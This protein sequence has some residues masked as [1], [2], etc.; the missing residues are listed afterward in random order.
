MTDSHNAAPYAADD[1]GNDDPILDDAR[2]RETVT[3][4]AVAGET[5]LP[6]EAD[7]EDGPIGG[8]PGEAQPTYADG[9]L[10]PEDVDLG[11]EEP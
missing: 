8:M 9:D 6:N 5:V 10:S 3:N 11:D 7:G 2:A 1:N 4:D